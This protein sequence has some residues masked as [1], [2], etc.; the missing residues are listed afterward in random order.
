MAVT[1]LGFVGSSAAYPGFANKALAT[2]T[3][4]TQSRYRYRYAVRVLLLCMGWA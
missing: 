3:H 2:A 4:F 1:R